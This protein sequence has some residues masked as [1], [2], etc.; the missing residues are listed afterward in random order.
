MTAFVLEQKETVASNDITEADWYCK[1]VSK[2]ENSGTPLNVNSFS[3]Y[4]GSQKCN[5]N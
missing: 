3:V 5:Y 1:E 4:F 2:L